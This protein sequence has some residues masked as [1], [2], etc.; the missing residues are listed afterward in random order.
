VS[1]QVSMP[2][3]ICGKLEFD[4]ILTQG[5]FRGI[6]TSVEVPHEG[7]QMKLGKI[8]A[9]IASAAL[10]VTLAI[11]GLFVSAEAKASPLA[12]MKSAITEAAPESVTLVRDGCGR[13]MR[14]SNR[15]QACVPQGGGYVDPGAAIVGGIAA[16]IAGAVI[17]PRPRCGPG[18]RWSDRRGA[19]VP[20]Y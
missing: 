12:A 20:R 9:T 11:G 4:L 19:C 7:N 13:G 15:R 3:A 2:A 5:Q 8:G 18:W 17:A 1:I 14:W 16:G 6:C 10:A